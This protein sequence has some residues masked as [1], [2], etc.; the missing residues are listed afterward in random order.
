LQSY[1]AP[2]QTAAEIREELERVSEIARKTGLL[3]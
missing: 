2:E 1:F 3:K